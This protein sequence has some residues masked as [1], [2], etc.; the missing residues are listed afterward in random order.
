M[1]RDGEHTVSEVAGVLGVSAPAA[2]KNIDKLERFGLVRRSRSRDD[3]RTT[4]LSVSHEGR[5]LVDRYDE[6][7]AERLAAV[8]AGFDPDEIEWMSSLLER[9]STLLLDGD[10][11][12]AGAC[13]RCAAYLDDDCAIGRLTGGCP[14]GIVAAS[15]EAG[16]SED[17]G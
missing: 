11:G 15:V 13:L 7:A 6:L 1:S 9:L 17:F 8:L 3:R 12:G 5:R 4:L 2:S 16:G 14:H 10:D